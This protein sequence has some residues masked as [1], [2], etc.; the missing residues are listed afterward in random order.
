MPNDSL[1]LG[2]RLFL[3]AY[4]T[5]PATPGCDPTD[6]TTQD[7]VDD[8]TIT[9]TIYNPDGTEVTPPPSFTHEGT[10]TYTATFT[11]DQSG[12]HLYY[13]TS[14]GNASGRGRTRFYVEPVPFS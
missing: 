8:T 6:S 7:P 5:D 10:G 3:R 11:P 14:I 13:T 4:L 9:A 2:Q 12:W 1:I